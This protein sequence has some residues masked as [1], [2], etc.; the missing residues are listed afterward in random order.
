MVGET[1]SRS[2][3]KCAPQ[4]SVENMPALLV[5]IFSLFLV[6]IPC[7]NSIA[8]ERLSPEEHIRQ[9]HELTGQ[10]QLFLA[11]DHYRQAIAQGLDNPEAYRQLSML[12]YNLGLVDDATVEME[13]AVELDP[14]Q[15]Y[16]QQELG[17]LY[18]V[19]D[20]LNEAE[21]ALRR[22]LKLDPGLADAYY[23]LGELAF[24]TN[25]LQEAWLYD[26][27]ARKAGHP[28]RELERK[29]RVLG[30]PPPDL[31][32]DVP[33]DTFDLR[34]V[35]LTD[36]DQAQQFLLRLSAG[37]R[38]D[39]LVDEYAPPGPGPLQGG[40]IGRFKR[41]ELLPKLADMLDRVQPWSAPISIESDHD[42][43]LVQRIARLSIPSL[44]TDSDTVETVDQAKQ[45]Q[46]AASNGKQTF[47]L[48][49]GSF[50][51]QKYA[52][53]LQKELL[54]KGFEHCYIYLRKRVGHPPLYVVVAGRFDNRQKAMNAAIN[55]EAL[56]YDYFIS[57]D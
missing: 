26:L 12:L 3:S 56:G 1:E 50:H 37:E 44:L 17:L 53:Q 7:G 8:D 55:L 11:I 5:I 19:K 27:A 33:P 29:L 51:D 22:A 35:K 21:K 18:L 20:R 32:W 28:G 36:P 9:A 47:F 38:F 30:P 54:N 6:V 16:L 34:Q 31:P 52:Q 45:E 41:A 15:D 39:R 40:Y 43:L 42:V 10:G 49:A 14:D 48:N 46:P 23:Y 24:K 2:T 57:H 4:S 25:H 13:K